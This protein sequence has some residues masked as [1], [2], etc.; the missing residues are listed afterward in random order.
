MFNEMSGHAGSREFLHSR[1]YDLIVRTVIRIEATY[2][3]N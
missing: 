3:H 1:C 2:A